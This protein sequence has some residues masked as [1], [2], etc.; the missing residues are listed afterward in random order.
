M[1]II[2]I[3]RPFVLLYPVWL[4]LSEAVSISKQIK[5][6]EK[7]DSKSVVQVL[8]ALLMLGATVLQLYLVSLLPGIGYGCLILAV[9]SYIISHCDTLLK[10]LTPILADN[11]QKFD[12]G[13][14]MFAS[15]QKRFFT[16]ISEFIEMSL[17][18]PS[19]SEITHC[20][21]HDD[22]SACIT[23]SIGVEESDTED[24]DMVDSDTVDNDDLS[25]LQRNK[26]G[27]RK[28]NSTALNK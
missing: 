26:F 1:G 14:D 24:I 16:R 23:P 25:I 22:A 28:R 12:R 13:I 18:A 5:E 21:S 17:A 20:S 27:L 10:P 8:K 19:E 2:E 6:S 7:P 15:V 9:A 11:L 3:I 4:L